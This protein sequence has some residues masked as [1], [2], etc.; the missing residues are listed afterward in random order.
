MQIG[1]IIAL[2]TEWGYFKRAF[3]LHHEHKLGG[4]RHYA[5]RFGRL[6]VSV[7]IGGV[8]SE[9]ARKASEML[10]EAHPLSALVSIGFAG[11]LSPELKRGD[12]VLSS[13]SMNGS[14]GQ[15]R[16]ADTD[17]EKHLAGIAD[18]S[19]EHHVS[20]SPLF[21]AEKIIAR[22]EEK[23]DIFERSN[24]R[25]VDMESFSIY[26]EACKRNLPFVGIHAITD[27][28]E[29]DIPA[30]EIINPFLT[31]N[32]LW[33][34]PRIFLDLVRR[35]KFMVDLALL[36]HDAQVAGRNLSHFLVSNRAN[37]GGFLARFQN[38]V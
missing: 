33:R 36:N 8:G 21:T 4:R 38:L 15:P 28:A 20:V 23:K 27:T 7:I 9:N 3:H 25:I 34:Y 16:P 31:S 13:Y 29:E 19:H 1:I 32:T 30:L 2:P 6:P 26:Q 24:A 18:E 37:L 35:P 22:H 17:L 5:G 14:S 11:A 12:I 10:C